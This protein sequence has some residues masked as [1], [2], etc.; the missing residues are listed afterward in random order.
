MPG[1]LR[2]DE[3]LLL[4]EHVGQFLQRA[5][6]VGDLHFECFEAIIVG[7]GGSAA[8]GAKYSHRAGR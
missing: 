8:A 1:V 6:Q 2:V 5:L 3:P 7:H 4:E